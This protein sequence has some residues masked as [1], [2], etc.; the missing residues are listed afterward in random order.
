LIGVVLGAASNPERDVHMAA[1]LNQGFDQMDVPSER[2]TAVAVRLPSLVGVA[3][4][5]SLSDQPVRQSAR[6]NSAVPASV[7]AIQVGSYTSERAAREAAQSARRVAEGG[8]A[9]VEQAGLRGRVTWRAQIVGLTAAEAQGACSALAR[10]RS[11][12]MVLRADQRQVASR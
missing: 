12:C 1:L 2:R 9:R 5:A 8:E 6:A 4:A 10:R 11:P 3:H 7:W